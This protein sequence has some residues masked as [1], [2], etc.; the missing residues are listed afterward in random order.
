MVIEEKETNEG[1]MGE[2]VGRSVLAMNQKDIN[3]KF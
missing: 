1:K 3:S 2:E